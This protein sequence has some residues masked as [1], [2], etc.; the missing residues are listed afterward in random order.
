MLEP[1]A[2]L[3]PLFE[4]VFGC[5]PGLSGLSNK[6]LRVAG[7]ASTFARQAQAA[8]RMAAGITVSDVPAGTGKA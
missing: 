1:G 2:W 8:G 6:R 7:P 4:A 5:G 3:L